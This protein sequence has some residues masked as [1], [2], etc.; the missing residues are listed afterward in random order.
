MKDKPMSLDEY[1]IQLKNT[2]LKLS[3]ADE[4]ELCA[5][6][7]DLIKAIENKD[8]ESFINLSFDIKTLKKSGFFGKK[9]TYEQM[10]EK[11]RW[12][13]GFENVFQ[14]AIKE[15]NWCPYERYSNGIFDTI[16][17]VKF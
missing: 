4:F 10:A 3:Q 6:V 5:E 16:K 7:R 13:F 15:G 14:Y 8:I 9:D 12:Y 2:E 11:V 17:K 1:L